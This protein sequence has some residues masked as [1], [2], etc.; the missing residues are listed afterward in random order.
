VKRIRR[1]HKV[2]K[3]EGGVMER[4][5]RDLGFSWRSI[6]DAMIAIRRNGTAGMSK[7][8]EATVELRPDGYHLSVI[9]QEQADHAELEQ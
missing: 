8:T 7:S 3:T 1:I 9:R 2:Y 5:Y 4:L 6:C